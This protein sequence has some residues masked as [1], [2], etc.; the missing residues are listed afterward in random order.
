[1]LEPLRVS[2]NQRYL[3]TE[4][5]NPFF[6]LA[7]TAWTLICHLKPKEIEEYFRK[8]QSQGFNVIQISAI[9]PETNLDLT[10]ALGASPFIGTNPL[11][12]NPEYFN[13]L[14]LILDLAD[15]YELY[16][17]LLPTWGELVTGWTWNC[18]GIGKLIDQT[19]AYNYG[20][21]LGERY[22]KRTNIVWVLGGDRHPVHGDEDYRPVWRKMAEG[23]A[24]GVT[25]NKLKWDTPDSAWNE[26]L[27]TYHPC[28][29]DSPEIYSSS[30]WLS[31]DAWLSFNMI[32]S[33][34]RQQVENYR[35]IL[36]DYNRKPTRPVLDGEP[37][38]EDWQYSHEF[39][40]EWDVRKRA[41]L[42]ILA[43][44]CGHTYGHSSVW[45]ML[46]PIRGLE[47]G[48]LSWRG[49]LDRPGAQ[50]MI[51]LR[52][53]MESRP[54]F[55]SI[56]DQDLITS[57]TWVAGTMDLRLQARI[58]NQGRFAL[59]YSTS[60]E[61]I[62]VDLTRFIG[63]YVFGWWFDP[64]TGLVCDANGVNITSPFIKV[65]TKGIYN[66]QPPTRGVDNDWLLV[67]DSE[68]C[69]LSIPGII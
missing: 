62:S 23:I 38:Y 24:H 48:T 43:G 30:Q 69:K 20:N 64:R 18:D 61:K 52:R 14:D 4:S 29:T 40:R 11:I 7:D 15:K 22:Q 10:N 65:P 5:G 54:I 37:N 21:W 25:G 1:M 57:R 6:W 2:Q 13:Y 17:A 55:D 36:E 42:S 41:Y 45:C 53:V 33:G 46:D 3:M 51:H 50:Q 68:N 39:H 66:F 12:I 67:L 34:H 32:Q 28:Y 44:G 60:G 19:N 31:D 27:L 56:P 49:A 58:D 16:I 63:E 8:R 59:I 26:L 35:Q 9:D 47:P